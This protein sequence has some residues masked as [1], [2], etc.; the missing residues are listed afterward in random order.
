MASSLPADDVHHY[1][2]PKVTGDQY[3]QQTS[4][5]HV[6]VGKRKGCSLSSRSPAPIAAFMLLQWQGN[7]VLNLGEINRNNM[8]TALAF[9]LT[10]YR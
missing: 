7:S 8:H 10:Y 3:F 5:I 1:V 9:V 2:V 6:S 4:G